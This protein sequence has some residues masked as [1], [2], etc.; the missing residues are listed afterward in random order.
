MKSL[1]V[2][3]NFPIYDI[4]INVL[5]QIQEQYCPVHVDRMNSYW[6]DE[7]WRDI[8]YEKSPGLF[9]PMEEK[10]TNQRLAQ[11]S[12]RER[13]KKV[14][15]FKKVPEP[16]A[17]RNSKNAVVYYL[18]FASYKDTAENIVKYIFDTFGKR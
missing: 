18:Y 7:S 2:F 5:H 9:G 10:V 12:L 3:I 11:S 13:L 6:G 15:G 14:A 16:L 4:N 17:M 8:A 1:D